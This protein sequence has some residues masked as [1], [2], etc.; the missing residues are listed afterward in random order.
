VPLAAAMS[1]SA[2][3]GALV[4]GGG[5]LGLAAANRIGSDS[6]GARMLLQLRGLLFLPALAGLVALPFLVIG[7]CLG[8]AG[9]EKTAG[10]AALGAA[11]VCL[12]LAWHGWRFLKLLRQKP[13]EPVTATGSFPPPLGEG[14]REGVSSTLTAGGPATPSP[15]LPQGGRES[16]A[17]AAPPAPRPPEGPRP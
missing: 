17:P 15:T 3:I 12:V 4:F 11:V 1:L 8:L 5:V 6:A 14:T 13:A 2:V 7:G 9:D 16:G 10:G